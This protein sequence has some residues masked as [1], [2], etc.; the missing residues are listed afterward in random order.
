MKLSFAVAFHTVE[1]LAVRIIQKV[2]S[3]ELKLRLAVSSFKKKKILVKV[4]MLRACQ[5]QLSP[6]L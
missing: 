3:T 6:L 5:N 4:A 2:L 1:E